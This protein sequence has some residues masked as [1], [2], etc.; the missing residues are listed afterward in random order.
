MSNILETLLESVRQE[1]QAIGQSKTASTQNTQSQPMQ[2]AGMTTNKV[3]LAS[4]N[5]EELE[6][7]AAIL[8][9]AG[10]YIA[11]AVAEGLIK[12]AQEMERIYPSVPQ[13]AAPSGKWRDRVNKISAIFADP[14]LNVAEGVSNPGS[15]NHPAGTPKP[16]SPPIFEGVGKISHNSMAPK[17]TANNT[18]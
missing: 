4:D 10:S 3:V 13:G 2:T 16:S 15:L 7:T 1:Q 18:H 9:T 8:K 6:K 11:E 17:V 12:I 14:A 5:A